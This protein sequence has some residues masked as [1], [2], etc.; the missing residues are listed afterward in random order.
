MLVNCDNSLH[1][2]GRI[3]FNALY[4]TNNLDAELFVGQ[5]SQVE[6]LVHRLEFYDAL[7]GTHRQ[8]Y[9]SSANTFTAEEWACAR[10]TVNSLKG[11]DPNTP[12]P[13]GGILSDTAAWRW[14][15][16]NSVYRVAEGL[17]GPERL[18]GDDQVWNMMPPLNA[19]L[20][21]N[22]IDGRYDAPGGNNAGWRL[23]GALSYGGEVSQFEFGLT[24]LESG[25]F[26]TLADYKAHQPLP[27]PYGDDGLGL[28]V[29]GADT[30]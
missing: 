2:V 12:L 27:W 20:G 23:M 28:W 22:A 30:R 4:P 13:G 6:L 7:A 10:C 8:A 29:P 11:T 16:E 5:G 14:R 26:Y 3:F 25:A 17:S 1:E 9:K 21:G 18:A 19:M 24:N 15:N